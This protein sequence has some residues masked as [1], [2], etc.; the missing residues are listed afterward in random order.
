MK[1]L[2]LIGGMALFLFMATTA[3]MVWAEESKTGINPSKDELIKSEVQ[4][5]ISMLD[6]I[7]A[8]V[9]KKEFTM[10]K[11][12]KLGAELLRNLRYGDKRDGYFWADTTEGVNVVLYGRKDVEG[13]NRLQENRNG[14]YYIKELI[15]K[16]SQPNGGY[17]DYWYT[18]IGSTEFL[19]K[20]A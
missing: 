5:A 18:K 9:L 14:V 7:H 3:N 13:K 1:N 4:T 10:E 6:A 2:A 20:R 17:T 19:P 16:G 15:V 12:K 11:A 8:M